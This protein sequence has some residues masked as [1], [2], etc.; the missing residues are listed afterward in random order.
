MSSKTGASVCVVVSGYTSSVSARDCN[1]ADTLIETLDDGLKLQVYTYGTGGVAQYALTEKSLRKVFVNTLRTKG[2][3]YLAS[4]RDAASV[5]D[6]G[7]AAQ[8]TFTWLLSLKMSM[9]D[10]RVLVVKYGLFK[11]QILRFPQA[12]VHQLLS[13]VTLGGRMF[14][15]E[16]LAAAR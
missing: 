7:V 12:E 13:E 5:E 6:L 1:E 11:E 8:A 2:G 16:A 10:A 15:L 3:K 4:V 14:L 9:A